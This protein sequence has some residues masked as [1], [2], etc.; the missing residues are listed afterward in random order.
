[1]EERGI[2]ANCQGMEQSDGRQRW[3]RNFQGSYADNVTSV[4]IDIAAN[5]DPPR[6]PPSKST[7]SILVFSGGSAANQFVSMLQSITDDICYMLP[8]SDDGG[9]TSE[10]VKVVGGPGI[11]DIRSRLVRLAETKTTEAS[12]VHNL[13]SY[14]L[15]AD[16][17]VNPT[18]MHPAKIEWASIVEGTHSLWKDISEPYKE[19]IRAFL[20]QFHYKI[21]KQAGHGPLFDFRGGSVG[22]F[23]LTG[24]RLFFDSLEA[25]IFQFAR[26]T[27]SPSRTDVMS[28]IATTRNTIAIAAALRDGSVVVGQCE[29]SHPG[30]KTNTG[31]SISDIPVF[32]PSTHGTPKAPRRQVVNLQQKL[33][34]KSVDGLNGLS[35][36]QSSRCSSSSN[37]IFSKSLHATPS[38][39]S[40]IR[41]V[42]YINAEHSETFPTLNELAPL[43]FQRKKTII[44]SMG[45]LYTS[46]IPC[47]IV[48]GVGSSLADDVEEPSLRLSSLPKPVDM[49]SSST[50]MS[51]PNKGSSP[52]RRFVGID[53]Q[54][55]LDSTS[56]PVSFVGNHQ[57]SDRV[58]IL[59]LNGTTDRETDGYSALDF[60]LAITDALNYSCIAE[61]SRKD[62]VRKVSTRDVMQ[63][64]AGATHVNSANE[65]YK[66]DEDSDDPISSPE[67]DEEMEGAGS[68]RYL[69]KPYP[70][71]SFI[72]HLVYPEDGEISVDVHRIE[73]MGI[74]CIGVPPS[75]AD[76]TVKGHFSVDELQQVLEPLIL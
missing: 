19:T 70:P 14:R 39:P 53:S 24:C 4:H 33:F 17:P 10:I 3:T 66:S 27:R 6:E 32:V 68:R 62:A 65:G 31:N 20:L 38:L 74:T 58:K 73:G 34:Q 8:V 64:M 28:I 11:G 37:L 60:I 50:S 59:L 71:R 46:L 72:T 44:Y 5:P 57:S 30:T 51:P 40:P 9:S 75:R 49:V 18:L 42:F 13:L 7:K 63:D 54:S 29:I 69:I 26:I 22:N 48:P 1:M 47:L 56:S 43:H 55:S 16:E 25:A 35:S 67:A 2:S 61:N 76:K 45:S 41:R 23:F 12:A 21:L 15:P 52:L 36:G